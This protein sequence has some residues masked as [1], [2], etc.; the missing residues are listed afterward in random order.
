MTSQTKANLDDTLSFSLPELPSV[1]RYY[2]DFTDCVHSIH[3]PKESNSWSI[4]MAGSKRLLDFNG[5]G[6]PFVCL[7]KSWVA[8]LFQNLAATTVVTRF[9]NLL[10]IP[11][12][13]VVLVINATPTTIR[14]L[15][16]TLLAMDFS[17]PELTSLKS[18]LHFFC[19][20]HLA[21]WSSDYSAFLATLPLPAQDKFASVRT[22]EAFLSVEEEAALV[23]Y[24][25]ELSQKIQ[26]QPE[27]IADKV[28]REITILICAYQFGL[29]PMQIGMLQMRDVR[30]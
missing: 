16:Q 5:Y 21:S 23:T 13:D 27:L 30:I 7:L 15:W 10:R 29:R 24:F 8:F 19:T 4:S 1:I 11:H 6:E 26:R 18:I 25:D 28:L 9:S 2:D 17:A 3:N 14:P 20:Y 22:G 12:K